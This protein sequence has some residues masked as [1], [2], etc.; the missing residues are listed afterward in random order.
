MRTRAAVAASIALASAACTRKA[1][2]IEETTWLSA[3]GREDRGTICADVNTARACWEGVGP[4]A[5]ARVPRVTPNDRD[6]WRCV[7]ERGDRACRRRS[8]TAGA[9]SCDETRCRQ[10][11]LR[12]PDDGEWECF[13]RWGAVVCRGGEPAS[14]VIGGRRDKAWI[15]GDVHS[16][17]KP[18]RVCVDFA[19]DRPD[20]LGFGACVIEE[21]AGGPRQ[22]CSRKGEPSLGEP[23]REDAAC[24]RGAVCAKGT[25]LPAMAPRP[26]CWL[27]T[28]CAAGELCLY[29]TCA[30]AT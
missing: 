10:E 21:T 23:C 18:T 5:V 19:P 14:G 15:C 27:D 3:P 11:H 26:S 6:R 24:P 12:A 29:A 8:G 16:A 13:E 28:D 4:G 25:C 1:V 9:F 20:D 22:V 30:R 2:E 17:T 7:G